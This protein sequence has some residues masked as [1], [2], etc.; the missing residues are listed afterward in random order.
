MQNEFFFFKYQ[1]RKDGEVPCGIIRVFTEP[2]AYIKMLFSLIT[3]FVLIMTELNA[4]L[5]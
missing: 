4:K 2:Y 1:I 3:Y 5:E